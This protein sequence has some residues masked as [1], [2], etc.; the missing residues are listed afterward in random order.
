MSGSVSGI[1]SLSMSGSHALS[2]RPGG[3]LV[4]EGG[5]TDKRH[6][7]D[8]AVRCHSVLPVVPANR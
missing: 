1:T 7:Q 8:R 4:W 3:W 5:G 2:S 6:I